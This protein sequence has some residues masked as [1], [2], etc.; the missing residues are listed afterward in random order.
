[1]VELARRDGMG[2][3][4]YADDFNHALERLRHTHELRTALTGAAA[5]STG[6]T[7]SG[8]LLRSAEAL[9]AALDTRRCAL[10]RRAA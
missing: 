7:L 1:M 10:P 9:S 8:E 6:T 4:Q 5:D 3:Y 2:G